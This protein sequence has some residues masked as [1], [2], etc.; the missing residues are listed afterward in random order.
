MKSR[1]VPPATAVRIEPWRTRTPPSA[2][3]VTID[4][5]GRN[6]N[7][8]FTY[9]VARG[10]PPLGRERNGHISMTDFA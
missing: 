2:F 5:G 8:G 7:V 3:A 9:L 10:R 4:A 6:F 1:D